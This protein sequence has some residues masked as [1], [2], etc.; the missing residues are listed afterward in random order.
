[1]SKCF[2]A[3]SRL[4][5]S[6]IRETFTR[7]AQECD[8]GYSPEVINKDINLLRDIEKAMLDESNSAFGYIIWLKRGDNPDF[9]KSR[10]DVLPNPDLWKRIIAEKK[11]LSTAN[12]FDQSPEIMELIDVDLQDDTVDA[13]NVSSKVSHE[14]PKSDFQT[15]GKKKKSSTPYSRAITRLTA[16]KRG[17]I[18]MQATADMISKFPKEVVNLHPNQHISILDATECF[19]RS[20]ITAKEIEWYSSM[21][22]VGKIFETQIARVNS[23]VS[24]PWQLLDLPNQSENE[25]RRYDE[26]REENARRYALA[27]AGLQRFLTKRGEENLDPMHEVIGRDGLVVQSGVEFNADDVLVESSFTDM[28][29]PTLKQHCKHRKIS[30]LIIIT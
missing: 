9:G 23:I 28:T 24:S 10:P 29:V 8:T 4:E 17:A 26:I 30:G 1:M 14:R 12:V 3:I 22:T 13:P 27:E 5:E 15:D 7:H 11:G 20:A 21:S 2:D 18:E 19:T 6:A 16:F 25:K